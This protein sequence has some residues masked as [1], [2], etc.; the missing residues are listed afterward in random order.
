MDKKELKIKLNNWINSNV[1]VGDTV[2]VTIQS[3]S[4]NNG[5]EITYTLNLSPMITN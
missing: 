3:I 2:K 5:E 1:D 4:L